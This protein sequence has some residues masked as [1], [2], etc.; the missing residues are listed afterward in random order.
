VTAFERSLRW[1]VLA[2]LLL[3]SACSSDGEG[4]AAKDVANTEVTACIGTS[5]GYADGQQA[6]VEVESAGATVASASVE[7]PGRVVLRIPSTTPEPRLLVGGSEW[8]SS[9]RGGGWGVS[10]GDGCTT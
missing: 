8:A 5:A 10:R 2:P 3:S 6:R 4:E 7:V 9:P 1:L